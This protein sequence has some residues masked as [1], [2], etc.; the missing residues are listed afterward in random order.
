MLP[1]IAVVGA[2][3]VG[4]VTSACLA[5]VGHKVS[6]LD[7]DEKKIARLSAGEVPIYEP[8]LQELVE[9]GIR[10]GTLTFSNRPA[11]VIPDRSFVFISV[12]TPGASNGQAD[13]MALLSAL[14]SIIPHL[15]GDTV[16]IQKSTVPVGTATLLEQMVM[17]NGRS[18][19]VVANPEFLREG[20]AVRDFLHPDRL[21]VGA[22]DPVAAE[23]VEKLF[24]FADCPVLRTNPNTAEMIKY[25]S[26]SFLATKISFINEIAQICEAYSV[27]VRTVAHG[28]GLD[29]RIGPAFLQ[30]GMGWGGSC[31][32]KDVKALIHMA[33]AA[34]KDPRILQ[35]VQQV[36]VNQRRQVTRKL[37]KVLG[38]LEGKVVGLLGLAFKPGTDDL[39][40][41]PAL[42]LAKLL[43][44]RRCKVRAHD[45]FAMEKARA[46]LPGVKMLADPYEMA[47][48]ADALILATDWPEYR[49]LDMGLI[50]AAMRTPLLIDGRNLWNRAEMENMGFMY[51]GFGVAPPEDRANSYITQITALEHVA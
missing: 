31:L 19:R 26:N 41:A 34:K 28:M 18:P 37:E 51:S 8:G 33:K 27:D 44:R 30:A 4:L 48:G 49:A 9:E 6:V 36:N 2:G 42:R 35:A 24:A 10:A 21:V 38:G 45:P 12:Q 3:Y 5:H 47:S 13:L 16:V 43:Q 39:R 29:E 46:A 15:D 23:R 14:R 1:N 22:T 25:A 11:A 17:E 50:H 20:T 40:Q 32:P 7:I